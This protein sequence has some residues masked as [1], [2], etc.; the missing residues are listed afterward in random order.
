MTRSQSGGR[1][2]AHGTRERIL[3]AALELFGAK[4]FAGTTTKEI[5]V[6]AGVNEVTVFRTFGT[7]QGLY[8]AMFAERSLVPSIMRSVEFDFSTPLEEMMVRNV[9]TVLGMLKANRH[10]FMLMMNDVW[11]QPRA[12]RTLGEVPLQRAIEFLASMLK[13]QMD[14]GRLRRM[15]PELAAR[16]MIGMVQAYFLTNYLIQGMAD[17]P[18]RDDRVVRGF[19]SIF[20]DGLRLAREGGSA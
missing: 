14:A 12:R 13:R 7:K 4:G 20:L 19:V 2:G 11:R 9:S 1:G 5:A 6:K 10:M 16:A 3:D 17:D 18:E 8:A 15:E